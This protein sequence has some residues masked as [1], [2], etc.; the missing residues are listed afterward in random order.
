MGRDST[1]DSNGELN[2][3]VKVATKVEAMLEPDNE[4]VLAGEI[5]GEVTKLTTTAGKEVNGCGFVCVG[6]WPNG[7]ICGFLCVK[8]EYMRCKLSVRWLRCEKGGKEMIW[9]MN[10]AFFLTVRDN[11]RKRR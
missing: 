5:P 1:A 2:F 7:N 9:E 8:Y 4:Q 10:G 3:G 11:G 6:V